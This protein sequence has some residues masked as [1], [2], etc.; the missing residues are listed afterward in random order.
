MSYPI[1]KFIIKM[2]FNLVLS[3]CAQNMNDNL[4]TGLGGGWKPLVVPQHVHPLPM[5]ITAVGTAHP[6]PFP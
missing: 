3:C 5:A 4:C 2:A 6:L 1:D